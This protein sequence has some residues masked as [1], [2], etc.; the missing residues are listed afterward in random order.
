MATKPGA[1]KLTIAEQIIE[2]PVS[3]LNFQFEARPDGIGIMRVYGDLPF[4][5]RE[6]LFDT[7]GEEAGAGVALTGL[8]RASWMKE[9]TKA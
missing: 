5:N 3:G 8:C 6:F 9:V 1:Q 4:G 2:D 7:N